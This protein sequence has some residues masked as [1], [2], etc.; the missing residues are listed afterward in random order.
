MLINATQQESDQL[1]IEVLTYADLQILKK[2]RTG[3]DNDAPQNTAN[4]SKRYLILTYTSQYDRVHFPLPLSNMDTTRL[5]TSDAERN[6]SAATSSQHLMRG[7]AI[8]HVQ[9]D[10]GDKLEAERLR[11]ENEQIR[12]AYEQLRTETAAS[13]AALRRRCASL[14][15][16]LESQAE[17]SR[18][19]EAQLHAAAGDKRL[20]DK[21]RSKIAKIEAEAAGE[22]TSLTQALN[23]S[24]KETI[25]LRS[26]LSRS[27][28]EEDRYRRLARDAH[29]EAK[30]AHRRSASNATKTIDLHQL[31]RASPRSG[32]RAASSAGS[33][34]SRG[35]VT[36]RGSSR[37]SSP[38][39][40]PAWGAG[41]GV[42]GVP[43]HTASR[44]ASRCASRGN[45]RTPSLAP[46]RTPS[47]HG[48]VRDSAPPSSA[49]SSRAT[50]NASS[51]VS[52][53]ANSVYGGSRPSSVERSR[54]QTVNRK[55]KP[56]H[57]AL[58]DAALSARHSMAQE[59][60]GTYDSEDDEAMKENQMSQVKQNVSSLRKARSGEAP[61]DSA[62]YNAM[63]DIQDI[64]RRLNALQEFLKQART[65]DRV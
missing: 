11:K 42:R 4:D 24:K 34:S 1:K 56:T 39:L 12:F 7:T 36:S 35:S 32:S 62:P 20:V 18:A 50:S 29:A 40:R 55:M 38:S 30:M 58:Q 2:K 13:V 33:V 26:E 63:E 5:D 45:S 16:D 48:S 3:A 43:S 44:A 15:S 14:S 57:Q 51:R 60:E 28:R 23:K 21:L 25:L 10:G 52:S 49:G 37:A 59:G 64:D 9:P 54:P 61:E 19:L 8:P 53:R 17:Q 47:R 46:S 6:P 31:H 65:P 27:K 22:R 41:P